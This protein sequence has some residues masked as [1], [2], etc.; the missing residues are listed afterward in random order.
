MNEKELRN[1]I[2]EL[3]KQYYTAKF[4]NTEF[5]PGKSPVRYAGRVFDEKELVNIVDSS[6]DFWLTAGRF[7]EE[8]E[9]EFAQLFNAA[10]A[11]LVNSGSS[12]NLV[13]ISALTSPKLKTED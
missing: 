2:L 9:Y 6:L 5:I 7:A 11:I 12:A 10:E 13:A 4:A 8:F 1:Q 3:T